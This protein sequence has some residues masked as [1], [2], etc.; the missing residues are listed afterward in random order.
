MDWAFQN[1]DVERG[2]LRISQM[3]PGSFD[4]IARAIYEPDGHYARAFGLHTLESVAENM[5][6]NYQKHLAGACN[7][8]VFEYNGEVAGVSRYFRFDER[9]K[10]LEI[11]G[12]W[13]APKWRRTPVNTLAKYLMLE[14]AFE[15]LGADRVEFCVSCYNFPSQ[16]AVLR[17]GA[18]KEGKLRF[19]LN[20]ID[21]IRD[22]A[23]L[24]SVVRKDWPEIRDRLES[25]MDRKQPKQDGL[26]THLLAKRVHLRTYDLRDA[27]ALL[28]SVERNRA[29]L[30]DS[31][32]TTALLNT[33]REVKSYIALRAHLHVDGTTTTYGVWTNSPTPLLIGQIATRNIDWKLRSAEFGYYIDG[34]MREQG[35]G[36]EALE[37]VT[38]ELMVQHGFNR[39]TL[40]ISPKN[41]ASLSLAK[42]VGFV[43]EGIMRNG[44]VNG[45]G[46]LE[47]VVLLSK[48]VTRAQ[49]T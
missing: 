4:R 17:I 27:E 11:G 14:Q 43:E 44:H 42:R 21:G 15:V 8:L 29:S 12:T 5:A 24:Y 40:R 3:K 13:I 32:T 26:A 18:K 28:D 22:D 41:L 36:R 45:S 49:D 6:E 9:R 1:I 35:F 20:S 38:E 25:L 16:M 2:G 46:G 31:L 30:F 48:T 39:L 34:E 23:F 19:V 7:P 33:D 47:D 37:R 10:S